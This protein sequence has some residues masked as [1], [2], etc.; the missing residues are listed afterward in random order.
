MCRRVIVPKDIRVLEAYSNL[1]KNVRKTT[2]DFINDAIGVHG[3]KYDY[4]KVKYEGNKVKICII[5]PE[6]GEFYQ[7]PN[8]HLSGQGCPQCGAIRA[9]E[10]NAMCKED[11]V[12]KLFNVNKYVELV[13]EYS[14]LSKYAET[15][16]KKCGHIWT[17]QKMSLLSGH[18]CPKCTKHYIRTELEFKEEINRKHPNI[19]IIG[20]YIDTKHQVQCQCKVCG[21]KWEANP[22]N[23]LRGVGCPR[24]AHGV[25]SFMELYILECMRAE[26]GEENV[27]SRDKKAIGMELDIYI[28]KYNVAIEPGSW[29][30][31]RNRINNDIE[32]QRR[33]IENG[34]KLYIIYDCFDD[35]ITKYEY[36][37]KVITFE[38]RLSFDEGNLVSVIET[39]IS[40]TKGVVSI[41]DDIYSEIKDKVYATGNKTTVIKFIEKAKNVHGDRYDYSGVQYMAPREKV[42]IVCKKHGGFWQYPTDHLQG[43]GC[44]KCAIERASAGKNKR[45]LCIETGTI[46][47][48]IQEASKA[49]G[50]SA[51]C[52]SCNLNGSQ[53]TA[54][55]FH[56][57]YYRN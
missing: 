51:S 56:W 3:D 26:F 45:V 54:G 55:G 46:F 42:L 16:C 43:H 53:K 37:D 8:N 35:D 11:F 47:S 15:R 57:E 20:E 2:K 44:S 38:S 41:P 10:A 34:I 12:D 18:G 40:D 21:L 29:Y 9:A 7:R 52:I 24:C 4:S 13:G 17:S 22:N 49:V 33:C 50:I 27:I 19:E 5:C 23:I 48:S 30:Y 28:P 25:T 14:L 6:H 32:K 36:L 1:R 31:H 39:I